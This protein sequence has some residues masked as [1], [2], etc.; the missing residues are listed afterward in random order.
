M[1]S[2]MKLNQC[3]EPLEGLG[4]GPWAVLGGGLVI[5]GEGILER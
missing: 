2:R 5:G 1:K 3:Q 4:G